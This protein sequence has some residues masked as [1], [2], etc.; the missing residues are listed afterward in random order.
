MD[1]FILIYIKAF[2]H[3]LNKSHYS[4]LYCAF[5]NRSQLIYEKHDLKPEWIFFFFFFFSKYLSV[6]NFIYRVT[7]GVILCLVNFV[8]INSVNVSI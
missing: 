7:L 8:Q 2:I 3:S 5:R 6:Q 1:L 4:Q